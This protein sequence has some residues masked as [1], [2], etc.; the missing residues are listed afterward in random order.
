MTL[1]EFAAYV[2][3][4]LGGNASPDA[5]AVNAVLAAGGVTGDAAAIKTIIAGM[6][7]KTLAEVC[8]EGEAKFGKLG[9]GGG[10]GGGGGTCGVNPTA[11]TQ[12]GPNF[13]RPSIPQL[14]EMAVV[15]NMQCESHV[16]MN[17]QCESQC[18]CSAQF[19]EQGWR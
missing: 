10:G 16:V 2:L 3:A 11:R 18:R 13:D 8:A 12:Q 14:L 9:G 15:M 1:Q 19:S 5:A 7:G 6:D 4:V 17:V